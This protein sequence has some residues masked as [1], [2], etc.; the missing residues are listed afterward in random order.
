MELYHVNTTSCCL[1]GMTAQKSELGRVPCKI[2]CLLPASLIIKYGI[3][4]TNKSPGQ[5]EY[6][7]LTK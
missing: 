1:T 2:V 7:H 3:I 6:N 4:L 5:D